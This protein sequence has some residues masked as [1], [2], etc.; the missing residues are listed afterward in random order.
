MRPPIWRPRRLR[1]RWRPSKPYYGVIGE[2]IVTVIGLIFVLALVAFIV[3]VYG[4]RWP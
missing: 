2:K 3:F 4:V 1:K